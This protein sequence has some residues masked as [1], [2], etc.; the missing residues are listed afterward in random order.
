MTSAHLASLPR[1]PGGCRNDV[2]SV[3][4]R[5]FWRYLRCHAVVR[6]MACIALAV[7][8]SPQSL[9]HS[10]HGKNEP[11]TETQSGDKVAPGQASI[12]IEGGKIVR[13]ELPPELFGFNIR[14]THFE[15]DLWD[16][17]KGDVRPTVVE[18]MRAF[19][20][21][22]Y[23]YPGGLVSN[24][25]DWEPT[26]Q[27][28][29]A[30][31]AGNEGRKPIEVVPLFGVREFAAFT[32]AVDGRAWY[33]LNLGGV[34]LGG[35][36]GEKPESIV[37]ESNKRLAKEL[38]ENDIWRSAP[39]FFELGNELDRSTYQWS[40]AKYVARSMASIK[41]ISSVDAKARFVAFLRE[42]NW[43]YKPPAE[44]GVSRYDDFIKDVLTGLPMVND[45]SLHMYYDGKLNDEGKYFHISD[46]LEK[47]DKAIK[48]AQKVRG[49][50]PLR[51]WITE[52]GRRVPSD[53]RD[54]DTAKVLT[55]N[56]S[57]A[58]ST[59]DFLIAMAQRPEVAGTCWQAL[60]GVGR[61]LFDASVTYGDLR[62]RPLYWGMRLLQLPATWAV[63]S[64]D[65]NSDNHSQYP[66]GYDVRATALVNP[67]RDTIV[68]W[69]VN[70]A[71]QPTEA[72][73]DLRS[74]T[75]KGAL[76][77]HDYIAGKPGVSADDPKE[78][79]LLQLDGKEL[80]VSFSTSGKM[81]ISLPPS[82]LNRLTLKLSRDK[83]ATP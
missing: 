76:L 17:K 61:Q 27:S 69:A 21:A 79:Y 12:V 70:R 57:A 18:H 34:R 48:V 5:R 26:L 20:G 11:K 45:F 44:P 53:K 50:T 14:W 66:G 58:L 4:C 68:V 55:G 67:A 82:S 8:V 52:H 41:A 1:A 83:G 10:G 65:T 31:A 24:H 33:T 28:L 30:R 51:V 35:V 3:A 78:D 43:R 72:S 71:T 81:A 40:H 13:N 23:R 47:L 6:S 22:L 75:A 42:F 25:F 80:P 37:A 56:L 19:P 49:N 36:P 32:K 29:A 64:T 63:L 38:L 39:H 54:A 62:P 7:C 60:H 9:A 15:Q 74:I 59:G 16:A 77:K 73:I 2:L 46:S